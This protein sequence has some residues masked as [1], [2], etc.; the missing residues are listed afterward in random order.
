MKGEGGKVSIMYGVRSREWT[1]SH[2]RKRQAGLAQARWVV[3]Q[4][5]TRQGV[6]TSLAPIRG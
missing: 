5:R 6:K 2:G 4:L 3:L 1:K